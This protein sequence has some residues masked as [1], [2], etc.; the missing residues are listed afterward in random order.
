MKY[1]AHHD[2]IHDQVHTTTLNCKIVHISHSVFLKKERGRENTF[3]AF[4]FRQ[5]LALDKMS[6]TKLQSGSGSRICLVNLSG[7][8]TI[9]LLLFVRSVF[10]WIMTSGSGLRRSMEW[11]AGPSVSV[12]VT[13][14]SFQLEHLIRQ[15]VFI[16]GVDYTH[17]IP[18]RAPQDTLR[19]E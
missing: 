5:L 8:L 6:K 3:Y 15:L 4:A 2:P 11:R 14:F 7:M 1:S 13:L 12:Q 18:H 10:I 16:L 9:F 19:C 17:L